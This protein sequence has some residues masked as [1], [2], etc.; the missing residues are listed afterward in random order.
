ML[1][2]ASVVTLSSIRGCWIV[3]QDLMPVVFNG[4]KTLRFAFQRA[5]WLA[6]I[7]VSAFGPSNLPTMLAKE[8]DE[9]N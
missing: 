1:V 5:L 3:G 8:V 2:E 7:R 6:F 4:Q 9:F